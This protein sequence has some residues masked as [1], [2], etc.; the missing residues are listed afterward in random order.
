M[1]KIDDDACPSRQQTLGFL[2][3]TYYD[4]ILYNSVVELSKCYV[5]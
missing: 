2:S 5:E 1:A 4:D 3:L